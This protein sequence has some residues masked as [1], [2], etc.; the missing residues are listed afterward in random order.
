MMFGYACEET[1][2]L[3]PLPIMLAHTLVMKLDEARKTE[4]IPYLKPDG[5][6]EVKVAYE[7]GRPKK[8]IQVVLATPHKVSV[9]SE[10]LRNDLY[11]KVVLPALEKYDFSIDKENLIVNG[12]GRWIVGGP[13][14]DTG[15]TGRKIIVDSYGGMA[16]IGGGCFSGKDPTKVDRTGA[17]GARFIAKNIV[18]AR[19]A[20]RIEVQ[21]A[22]VIGQKEPLTKG[23][24]VFG[25]NKVSLEKIE[26]FAWGLLDLSPLGIINTL[27]LRKPIYLKS[28]SYGHFG[29]EIFPWEEV[30]KS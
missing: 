13:A 28:A 20:S 3:M 15:V 1:P 26:K 21:L 18:A 14:S 17:Y 5:K 16:R 27:G 19:L 24:E 2:E 11:K 29:R 7:K 30:V 12:T 10:Q 23:I 25:T 22:Y 6:S 8:V 9:S 4:K